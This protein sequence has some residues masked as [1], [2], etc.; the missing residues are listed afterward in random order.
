MARCGTEGAAACPVLSRV[1]RR[2]PAAATLAPAGSGTCLRATATLC[3]VEFIVEELDDERISRLRV[4][5]EA[6]RRDRSSRSSDER[7]P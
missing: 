4:V 1:S 5:R 2:P 7:G 3:R 6:V